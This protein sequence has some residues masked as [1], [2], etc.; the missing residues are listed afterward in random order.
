MSAISNLRVV[1]NTALAASILF[2]QAVYA[3]STVL[4]GKINH[5]VE[6]PRIVQQD[7][8]ANANNVYRASVT[9]VRVPVAT[10]HGRV[11]YIERPVYRTVYVKDDRTFF[12]RH[13]KVKSA[14]IGAGVGAGV[15]GVTGLITHAGFG[16]GAL[17]G[18]GTGAGVGLVR[19]SDTLRSHPIVRNLATGSLVG[20]GIGGAASRGH[21]RAFQGA[22][23][24]AA[25]GLGAS[26]LNGEFR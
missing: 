5:D 9:R 21:S 4:T 10:P 7:A 18:A 23:I 14:A 26:L 19:S 6:V 13:P 11:Q 1:L 12:Q 17:I 22:G 20:L 2:S 16:R 3:Q 8:A 24:G 25:V 15:G